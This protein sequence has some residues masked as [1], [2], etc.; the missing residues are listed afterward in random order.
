[1]WAGDFA[2]KQQPSLTMADA[3]CMRGQSL[4]GLPLVLLKSML[5]SEIQMPID[6]CWKKKPIAGWQTVQSNTDKPPFSL[7]CSGATLRVKVEKCGPSRQ[8]CF[9]LNDYVL[10]QQA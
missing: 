3:S 8:T 5:T 4:L 6:N 10:K 9:D 2:V 1:M 7:Q